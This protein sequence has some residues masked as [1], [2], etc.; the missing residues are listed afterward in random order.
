ML[1]IGQ[2][3]Y[4]FKEGQ[5][6]SEKA[7][8]RLTDY[9]EEE[10]RVFSRYT[11]LES[12]LSVYLPNMDAHYE[13]DKL[14][15][16]KLILFLVTVLDHGLEES[17]QMLLP[18]YVAENIQEYIRLLSTSE[19][20][21]N[22]RHIDRTISEFKSTY[23]Q[24]SCL[25]YGKVQ[26][27]LRNKKLDKEAIITILKSLYFAHDYMD[28]A[29]IL[30]LRSYLLKNHKSDKYVRLTQLKPNPGNT[31]QGILFSDSILLEDILILYNKLCTD[32]ELIW[33]DFTC[34]KE[35]GI[36]QETFDLVLVAAYSRYVVALLLF[37]V[38]C[39]Y[40]GY[41]DKKD[42]GIYLLKVYRKFGFVIFTAIYKYLTVAEQ[43]LCVSMLILD[44]VC[45]YYSSLF[46]RNRLDNARALASALSRDIATEDFSRVIEKLCQK[47][48]DLWEKGSEL[49]HI[50]MINSFKKQARY[51][52]YFEKRGFERQLATKLKDLC[53]EKN[54]PRITGIHISARK[55]KKKGPPKQAL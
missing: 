28:I 15:F 47:A 50:D 10:S 31:L 4:T 52:T 27:V 3:L 1:N 11:S 33:P 25:S 5:Y 17:P 43:V 21:D 48:L 49:G 6:I 24:K 38:Q 45:T 13:D 18:R 41:F 12:I 54:I 34:I 26:E 19:Y 36:D 35:D 16:R 42:I 44:D 14:E 29:S 7:Q 32:Y 20:A 23:T 53:R 55:G 37:L 8:K 46:T 51:K 22:L 30:A 9:L 40:S 39:D 2:L